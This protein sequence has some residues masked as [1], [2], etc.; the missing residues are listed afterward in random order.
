MPSNEEFNIP[1]SSA[2]TQSVPVNF[3]IPAELHRVLEE[4]FYSRKFP[5]RTISDLE[6]HAM[7]RHAEWLS[8][9]GM[10]EAN[11]N[12]IRAMTL[13]LNKESEMTSF[14]GILDKLRIEVHHHLENGDTEDATRIISTIVG[15]INDM[16]AGQMKTRHMKR[17][18][19]EFGHIAGE[20]VEVAPK[21]Q[22]VSYDLE[23]AV[24]DE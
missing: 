22:L 4:L 13:A 16:P 2:N 11:T 10:V 18:M 6:R 21:N 5:Y 24:D 14:Q 3:R 9:K 23:D 7:V 19:S 8:Q 20:I 17:V 1:P 12:F 15:V